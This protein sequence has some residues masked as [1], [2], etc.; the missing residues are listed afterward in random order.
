MKKVIMKIK[1]YKGR[2]LDMYY[3][4]KD[5]IEKEGGKTFFFSIIIFIII[6]PFFLVYLAI[7]QP[8]YKSVLT[9][10]D[11]RKIGFKKAYRNNFLEENDEVDT[12]MKMEDEI[13]KR[14]TLDGEIAKTFCAKLLWS[15]AVVKDGIALYSS[16]GR[17]LL[18]VHENVV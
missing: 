7:I 18:Y 5:Y 4:V 15:D 9:L 1:M 8:V 13:E 2:A 14:L 10:I 11:M 16:D 17:T 6:L 3:H 12:E